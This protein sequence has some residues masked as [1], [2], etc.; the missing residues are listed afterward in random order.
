MGASSC[1]R[2][3]SELKAA[4]SARSVLVLHR[5]TLLQLLAEALGLRAPASHRTCVNIQDSGRGVIASFDGFD[6]VHAEGL[7]GAMALHSSSAS[8]HPRI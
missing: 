4:A 8:R 5:A 1:R 3:E 2:P 7:V 6:D